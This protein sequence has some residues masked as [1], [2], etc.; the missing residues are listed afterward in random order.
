MSY[1]DPTGKELDLPFCTTDKN[2]RTMPKMQIMEFDPAARKHV[3]HK[4]AR[5]TSSICS[6][7]K[8]R[9]PKCAALA[10]F[11]P[12]LALSLWQSGAQ[13]GGFLL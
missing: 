6:F 11:R 9:P 13:F 1:L 10:I 2:R 3:M 5:I 12:P 8:S 4:E 7:R